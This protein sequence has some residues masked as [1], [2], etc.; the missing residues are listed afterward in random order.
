MQSRRTLRRRFATAIVVLVASVFV[1]LAAV[2]AVS[3][4]AQSREEIEE[5][6]RNH[7]ALAT[8]H[9]SE[10]Y[11]TY[12]FSGYSKFR[13]L[14]ARIMVRNPDLV[15]VA[16]FDTNGSL[17]FDSVE[18]ESVEGTPRT[19]PGPRI[20][21]PR[22][23]AAV[24]GLETEDWRTEGG[25]RY[26]VVVPYVEEWG[27]HR[28]SVAFWVS[29]ESLT[30][31]TWQTLRRLLVPIVA[32]LA[33]GLLIAMVL[34]RQSLQPVEKLAA[35]A[36]DL[37]RG[38]LDRRLDLRTGDEFEAL[39]DTFNDMADRLESTI[40]DLETSNE[41]LARSNVHLR[42]ID[43]LKS[44]LLANVSHELRTPLTALQGYNEAISDELL[45][46]V[47][48]AQR[49]A[50]DVSERNLARLGEMIDGLLT[51]ARL[52]SGAIEIERRETSLREV[53]SQAVHDLEI[54]RSRGVIVALEA[55][56]RVPPV[57]ADPE[58]IRQ[59]LDNLLAN[60]VKFT[61]EGDR[62]VLRLVPEDHQV[63]VEVE[64]EGIGIAPEHLQRIFERFF[65]VDSSSTR[66]F[67]GIGL[68]LSI[69]RQI[70]DAHGVGIEV[71]SEPGR[72]TTF[73]FRLP[74]AEETAVE[75]TLRRPVV[76]VDDDP[77]W[78]RAVSEQLEARGWKVRS[79][80]SCA[81]A[82]RLIRQVRP[83]AVV[84][85][86]LLVDGDGFDVLAG[87]RDDAS[88][89]NVPVVVVSIRRDEP[90]ARRLGASDYLIKPV[91]PDV[92]VERV[93]RR[94]ALEAG[95]DGLDGEEWPEEAGPA[96]GTSGIESSGDSR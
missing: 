12:Y 56:D 38:R 4:R 27:R 55:P 45:G 68:G 79:A 58:R 43:R 37:A 48:E 33:L 61:A 6:A 10:A 90:L 23:L 7:A 5:T 2:L 64:D 46:P 72:G 15:R 66:A 95:S 20:A 63:L 1:L 91:S 3:G 82:E 19:A 81:G 42:E 62:V 77:V 32:S 85:D 25:D 40:Q 36:R 75:E 73:R 17:L 35:G 39:A 60:A 93:E 86:R 71:T 53:G 34:A 94:L 87:W 74:V 11:S 44:D 24:R 50:L 26:L 84:L 28:Y 51:Y 59:V 83:A 22:L 31:A 21:D 14:V 67:G 18:L 78:V 88:L 49:E 69:V 52:E 54:A 16:I 80:D 13:E 70:L 8:G 29:Y 89:E 57:F 9:L 76:V 65:Q 92:V 96:S 30:A 41:A 47:T